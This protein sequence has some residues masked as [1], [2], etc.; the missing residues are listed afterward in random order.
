MIKRCII[1][2]ILT[3]M[4]AVAGISAVSDNAGNYHLQTGIGVTDGVH[5]SVIVIRVVRMPE[6]SYL[7]V[8]PESLTTALYPQRSL[9]F[10][11]ASWKEILRRFARTPYVSA[12]L[13]SADSADAIQ[14]AGFKRFHPPGGDGV[15][16]TIDL[17][18]SRKPLDRIVFTDLV[19]A[20]GAVERPIPVGISIT[21]RWM[22]DHGGDLDWLDSLDRAGSLSILWINHT[23]NHFTS[24]ELPLRENFILEKGTDVSAEVLRTEQ[25]LLE[26]GLM[27]S[28]FFRFP[29]LVSDS[30]VF[31]TILDFG[32]IPVG[33]DAWLAK[34]EVPRD[35]SI[36]LIH[37]NGNEPL[38]VKDFIKLLEKE[39]PQAAA[40]KWKLFNLRTAVI[41]DETGR[42]RGAGK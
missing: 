2:G 11:P 35:G 14:D 40:K 5:D 8:D 33:S 18:P 22:N 41:A 13:R 1:S 32:L 25:A 39:Q 29:G 37:A 9:S 4:V 30:A 31:D 19:E 12:L 27:P 42:R 3:L 20:L 16:L 17:C 28:V 38:G 7:A 6:A 15:E 21:G 36:V 26:R 10:T 24:K 23:Y 34:G